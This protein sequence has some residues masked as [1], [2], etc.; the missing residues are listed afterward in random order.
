M[1]FKEFSLYSKKTILIS[2]IRI[3]IALGLMIYAVSYRNYILGA[4]AI[5]ISGLSI[6][7]RKS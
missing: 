3:L 4:L 6:S 1:N 5:I 7:I 2:I